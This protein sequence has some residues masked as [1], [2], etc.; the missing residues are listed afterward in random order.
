MYKLNLSNGPASSSYEERVRAMQAIVDNYN[1]K[2][3]TLN[4]KD[5]YNCDICLNKGEIAYLREYDGIYEQ[6]VKFCKCRKA[7]QSIR[8][9]RNS[10]LEGVRE[11]FRLDN[12]T[13]EA[14]YQKAMLDAAQAY[15]A[16][17]SG[18]WIA[19]LGASGAGKTHLCS[20]IAIN[21]LRY[22]KEVH[23]MKWRET[24]RQ[25]MQDNHNGNCDLLD[26]VKIVDVL[27]IDDLFKTA[28]REDGLQHP[29]EAEIRLAFEIINARYSAKKITI[30]SS[31]STLGE[32]CSIDNATAGRIRQMCGKYVIEIP[33]IKGEIRDYRRKEA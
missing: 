14:P 22:G 26:R 6:R 13:V 12:F 32:L 28:R 25:I 20:A 2:R 23:Y 1:K 5:G 3:G 33:L 30:I 27:Y 21:Y 31:E 17:E 16:D 11:D 29:S 10:G 9:L 24:V 4:E 7:R 18:K 8:N 19:Y 15:V